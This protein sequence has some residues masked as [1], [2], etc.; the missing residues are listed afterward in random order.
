MGRS[1]SALLDDQMIARMKPALLE[2][3]QALEYARQSDADH[4]Q[5]AMEI[6]H[7]Q[8]HGLTHNDLRLLTSTGLVE[9]ARETTPT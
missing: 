2:L 3:R 1:E 7:L 8:S 5:F 4:W 6:Q 9:H